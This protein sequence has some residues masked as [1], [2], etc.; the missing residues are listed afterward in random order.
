MFNGYGVSLL[1]DKVLEIS[2]TAM[3]IYLT[4]LNWSL[5]NDQEGKF[6]I[7]YFLTTIKKLQKGKSE[8]T[9]ITNIK[10]KRETSLK[11]LKG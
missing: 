5:R 9:Q 4:L 2:Y 6:Y 7:I 10:N 1:P 3:W 11:T 8:K